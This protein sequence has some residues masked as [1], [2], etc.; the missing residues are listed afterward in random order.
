MN[1]I[2][3]SQ[4]IHESF[5]GVVPELASRAHQQDIVRVVNEALTSVSVNQKD[6]SAIAFTKGP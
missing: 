5:G 1:N 3:A 2:V 6:L 4:M